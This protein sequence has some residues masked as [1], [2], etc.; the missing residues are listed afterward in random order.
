MLEPFGLNVKVIPARGQM[1]AVRGGACPIK[2]VLHS[3]KVYVVPRIDGRILIGATVE[4][5]GFH[6]AVTSGAINQLLG[7][8]VELIPS[9]SRFEVDE[10]WC[11]LRPD[12]IDHLPIIGAS[13]IDNLLLATA[14][15]RNEILLA[16][17]TAELIGDIVATGKAPDR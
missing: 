4:Y 17:I 8:A 11:G 1:V 12:T 6:K 3:S 5:A 7:A 16:P 14:H 10:V 13:G 2:R 9:I 15:F